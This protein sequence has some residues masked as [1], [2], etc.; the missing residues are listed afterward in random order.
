[1]AFIMRDFPGIPSRRLPLAALLITSLAACTSGGGGGNGD[2]S[3]TSSGSGT[4]SSCASTVTLTGHVLAGVPVLAASVVVKDVNGVT[5]ATTSNS[6]DGGYSVNIG[7]L[8]APIV[9]EA[10]GVAAGRQ[11]VLHSFLSGFSGSAPILNVNPLTEG[12]TALVGGMD[13]VSYFAAQNFAFLS[14]MTTDKVN[15][16]LESILSPVIVAVG[17]SPV[18][19]PG[20]PQTHIN[21]FTDSFSPSGRSGIDEAIELLN[22]AA[23]PL[24]VSNGA[25]TSEQVQIISRLD[26]TQRV[27]LT[28]NGV[29][30]TSMSTAVTSGATVGMASADVVRFTGLD[31]L[32]GFGS[33][34]AFISTLNNDVSTGSTVS[35]S[36]NEFVAGYVNDG[37]VKTTQGNSAGYSS[38]VIEQCDAVQRTCR[39]RLG[40]SWTS[41]SSSTSG[42]DYYFDTLVFDG[43]I[44]QLKGNG[45]PYHVDVGYRFI[46]PQFPPTFADSFLTPT[47]SGLVN[48]TPV[49]QLA[50]TV[51][52]SVLEANASYVA[53]LQSV[54]IYTVDAAG[55]TQALLPGSP[56][57]TPS[58]DALRG[59]ARNP[60]TLVLPLTQAQATQLNAANGHVQVQA[61]VKLEQFDNSGTL[62]S[63]TPV[64]LTMDRYLTWTMDPG[65]SGQPNAALTALPYPALLDD[66][67]SRFLNWIPYSSELDVSATALAGPVTSALPAGIPVGDVTAILGYNSD[68]T[69]S[70]PP[71]V[72]SGEL[73]PVDGLVFANQ[74]RFSKLLLDVINK[75][76]DQATAAAIDATTDRKIVIGTEDQ[77]QNHYVTAY[78]VGANVVNNC[79]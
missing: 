31:G 36:Q 62:I 46:S 16:A 39:V 38:P 54:D 72:F 28:L 78:C 29:V 48:N 51:D 11:V 9:V 43:V 21:F 13:P 60:T 8:S 20:V 70:A 57:L 59:A 64:P 6:V 65:A 18:P 40:Y 76:A 32:S 50:I 55:G 19:G 17:L 5:R 22:F 47:P 12:M 61:M 14:T 74:V 68:L 67:L 3:S 56:M 1:M 4:V 33:I 69:Q 42:M 53:T 71:F 77:D 2:S 35:A 58:S 41:T 79:K 23:S 44:W 34:D 30:I 27:Q 15:S 37:Q 52:A 45:L 26:P 66:T 63:T 25:V 75:P 73:R 10:S 49:E 7:C 24:S